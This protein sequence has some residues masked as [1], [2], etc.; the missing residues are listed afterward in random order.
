[1]SVTLT[2]VARLLLLGLTGAV[3]VRVLR[4][5]SYR[6]GVS[7]ADIDRRLPGDDLIPDATSVIDRAVVFDASPAEVWPWILQLGKGRAGWY[8]PSWVEARISPSGRGLRRIDPALQ[9]LQVGDAVSDWG[10]GTPV[11]RVITVEAPH[12]LVYLSLRDRLRDWR[13][14]IQDGPIQDDS[15]H[16]EPIS[17]NVLAFS[18]ALVLSDAGLGRTRLHIRLRMRMKQ[19]RLPVMAAGGLFDYVTIRLL[20]TGLAERLRPGLIEPSEI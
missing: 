10:P 8:L 4:T 7:D 17:P 14:P 20:F 5:L 1:V 19:H 2:R 9:A 15:I 13:W 3:G 16:D 18:W 6:S 11:F 12:A